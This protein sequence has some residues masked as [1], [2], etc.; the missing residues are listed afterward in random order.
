MPHSAKEG[1]LTLEKDTFFPVGFRWVLW[2]SLWAKLKSTPSLK[3]FETER[4]YRPY[5]N[6]AAAN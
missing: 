3:E 5:A 2:N 1:D 4:F 6:M